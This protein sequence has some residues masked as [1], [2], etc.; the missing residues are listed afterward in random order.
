[1]RRGALAYQILLEERYN[2]LLGSGSA[3]L[4]LHAGSVRL[5]PP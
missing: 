2:N 1:M 4:F 3:M 5:V